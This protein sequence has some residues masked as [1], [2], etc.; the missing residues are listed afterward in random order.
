MRRRALIAAVLVLLPIGAAAAAVEKTR[1]SLAP[2]R[3]APS[4]GR[5][6]TAVVVVTGAR[7]PTICLT[8][9]SRKRMAG[10][11]ARRWRG[12]RYRARLVLP[13][14]G[15]WTLVARIGRERF[16][17]GAVR[18]RPV[19]PPP[20]LFA[21]PTQVAFD[22]NGALLL[23]ENGLGR[24]A[25]IE[26]ATGRRTPFAQVTRPFGIAVGSSGDVYVSDANTVRRIDAARRVTTVAQADSDVGP[27]AIDSAGNVFFSTATRI[28]RIDG[29]TGP[30][31]HYAGTGVEGGGGDG[32]PARQAQLS[33][34]HGLAVGVDGA[35]YVSDTDN[36]RIRRI[37]A[38]SRVITAFAAARAPGGLAVGRDGTLY[39]TEFETHR[40]LRVDRAGNASVVA[41]TGVRGSTGDGGPATRARLFLPSDVDAASD[42]TL[43]IVESGA[44]GRIRRVDPSGTISTLRRR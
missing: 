5:P 9:T 33:G 27:L 39:V 8:A 7:P 3:L 44:A 42:G 4:V 14:V 31:T 37:D 22:R 34:P 43:Y 38:G 32:G 21:Y 30:V 6:W 19:S 24:V 16:R 35:L 36:D 29:G 12:N 41:G 15:R 26:P 40:L 20:L 28:F 1:V 2:S 10:A 11:T 17:L 18:A 23:V 13:S 25:R